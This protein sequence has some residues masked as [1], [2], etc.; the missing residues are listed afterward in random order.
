M[1]VDCLPCFRRPVLVKL[2]RVGEEEEI[3]RR[4]VDVVTGAGAD[5]NRECAR[6]VAHLEC[7]KHLFLYH[8]DLSFGQCSG[9]SFL[10]DNVS[11]L[12][13]SQRR[14]KTFFVL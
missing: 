7:R 3:V 12:K 5:R 2:M 13:F 6:L 1:I 14:K 9:R 11:Y 8:R 10:Q 4:E